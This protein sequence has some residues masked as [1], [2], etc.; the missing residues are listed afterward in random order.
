MGS[1]EGAGLTSRL[2]VLQCVRIAYFYVKDRQRSEE[3]ISPV[4][5]VCDYGALIQNRVADLYPLK[6]SSQ[7]QQ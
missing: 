5:L 1:A 7:Y 3:Q 4:H 2:I 6:R